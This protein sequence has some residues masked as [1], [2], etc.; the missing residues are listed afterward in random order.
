MR[1]P[2]AFIL[3]LLLSHAAARAGA[4]S[5]RVSGRVSCGDEPVEYGI[6][7]LLQPSDSSII[8]Y[9]TTDEQGRY[10]VSAATALE[11]LLIRVRGFNIK[12]QVKRIKNATQTL[13]FRAEWESVVLREVK[14][15]AQKL[16]GSRDT[17]N[18]LVSAYTRSHDRTIGDVLRQLPGITVED[19]GV[20]KYQGT[21]INHFYIENLDMLR[22]RYNLATEGIRADDVAT[23]QVL[24]NHEHVKA[25]R[26]QTPPESAAINL[27]LKDKSKGVWSK[28]GDLGIGEFADGVL[29]QAA[30][31]AMYF[32]KKEQHMLRYSGD[33]LGSLY[34]DAAP[35]YDALT[36]ENPQLTDIV[37][38][39][40]APVGNSRFGYRHGVNLSNLARLNENKTIN[41]NFN[42]SH[43]LSH[44]RSFSRTTY[45][46]PD[47]TELLLAENISDRIHTNS[48]E[49]QLSYEN[50]SAKLYLGNT[51]SLFGRWNE[52]RGT[53]APGS[54][55]SSTVTQASHY[56]SLGLANRTRIVRRTSGGGGWE[57]T[58]ANALASGP[59]ALAVG[60]DMTARQ[61]IDLIALS[62]SN[63][64]ELLRD[65][66]RHRW[67][68]TA[69]AHLNA[70]YTTLSSDLVHPEATTATHGDMD[71]LHAVADIG[72]VL[73]YSIRSLHA[74]LSMPVALTYT[75]LS[76]A[77]I[78]DEKTDAH[79]TRLRLQPSLTL[80]WKAGSR[81]T[82]NAD[83]S[84]SAE[85]TPWAKL[86]TACLM[87]N[88]R[89][90]SRYRATLDDSHSAGAHAKLSYKDMFSGL[91]AYLE[92]GWK[93]LWSDIAY[94]TTLDSQAHTVI[95]ASHMPNHSNR[96]S[97]SA[98]GRKDISWHTTQI[99]LQATAT[100]LRSEMLRQAVLSTFTTTGSRLRGSL[101]FDIITGC[102]VDYSATWM[103]NRSVSGS[104]RTTYNEWNQRGR[105]NMQLVP[106]RLI[107][108]VNLDHTHNSSLSSSRKDY[109]FLGSGMLWKVCKAVDLNLDGD[110]LTNIRRYSSRSL[111]DMEEYYTECRLRPLSV[112]LTAHI[113]L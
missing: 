97:L 44:G 32:G 42:Y 84:Y 76:N 89:S 31:Q 15:K 104:H 93:R 33:D 10:S 59:Q 46:L 11:E 67:A 14:V 35:L 29:W 82:L 110:N 53:I 73:K 9:T 16:W 105:L 20:I 6:V 107:L 63:S 38:H 69:T 95:E 56:R 25:L 77:A 37:G 70:K 52:G 2:L 102:R 113:R 3:I 71:H 100:R 7:A 109:V 47:D 87:S 62:T 61:D 50:N 103:R 79:R 57:W 51:L 68:L 40:H 58:S 96:F 34:D 43:N 49:A 88:Y 64:F 98:Y 112:T 41:Y 5:I 94:G 108:N 18:Y 30:V 72:P 45:I 54:S 48:A 92:G 39:S 4:D 24:E 85:E 8:A 36:Q 106:S 91:F 23:V 80:L 86:L 66:T 21:P 81:F 60:G 101:S 1:R 90:L 26:D 55:G 22:G 83:A 19:N 13:N 75:S 65:L 28:S 78:A 99:E 12:E 27:K 17:L 74:S 111:G